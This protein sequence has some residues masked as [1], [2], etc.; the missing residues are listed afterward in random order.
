MKTIKLLS[1]TAALLAAPL[2]ACGGPEGAG[3]DE[4]SEDPAIGVIAQPSDCGSISADATATLSSGER[5]ETLTSAGTAY[6]NRSGCPRFVADFR[7]QAN[8]NGPSGYYDDFLVDGGSTGMALGVSRS[9][10][11]ARLK[12]VQ[13]FRRAWNQIGFSLENYGVYRGSWSAGIA[14]IS[15]ICQWV[16][17]S[18]DEASYHD[19]SNTG[20]DVY[21]IAVAEYHNGS[22]VQVSARASMHQV[23]PN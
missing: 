19:A 1:L 17:I 11:E 2:V 4:A 16:L 6:G 23:P 14:P 9:A 20:T 5:F 13:R 12:Y 15:N 7:I 3:L 8:I 21:R 10:C 22:E 18:G